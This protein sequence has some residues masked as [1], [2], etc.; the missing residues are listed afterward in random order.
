MDCQNASVKHCFSDTHSMTTKLSVPDMLRGTD[1]G[2]H[3][4]RRWK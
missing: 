4:K 3:H 2:T 1:D